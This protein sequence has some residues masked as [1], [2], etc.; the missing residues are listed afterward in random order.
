MYLIKE[1]LFVDGIALPT[2]IVYIHGKGHFIKQHYVSVYRII[3]DKFFFEVGIF[4]LGTN[5]N[6]FQAVYVTAKS[7]QPIL[8]D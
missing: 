6:I 8:Q 3:N 5:K 2:D 4:V 1:Y 7:M